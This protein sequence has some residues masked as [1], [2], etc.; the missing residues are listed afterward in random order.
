MIE[1][2]QVRNCGDGLLGREKFM[3]AVGIDKKSHGDMDKK[4]LQKV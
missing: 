4:F 2:I 1:E 3:G